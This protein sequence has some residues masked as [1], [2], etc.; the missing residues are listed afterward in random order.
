MSSLFPRPREPDARQ[1]EVARAAALP[2]GGGDDQYDELIRRIG[3]ARF[4]LLGEA[5][6]GTHE[7]YE[8]RARI[9][10]RLIAERGFGAVAIEGDW[11]DAYRVNRFVRGTME[12][13]DATQALQGFQRFPSWMWRNQAVVD[14][15]ERLRQ[16]NQGRPTAARTGFY[17]LDLYSLGASMSA[18]L[19]FL[20]QEDPVVAA[21][22]RQRYACFEPFGGDS[23]V[24]GLM[25]GL[26]STPSCEEGAVRTLLDLQQRRTRAPAGTAADPEAQFDA[27]QNALLVRDAE[28]YYRSMYLDDVSSWN[29]RDAHMAQ[30]L[31]AID[32]H[33][34][35]PGK[36]ARIVVWAH[37]SH[38]GDAY[39]TEM[40]QARG[41]LNLGQLVRER[42]PEDCYLVGF[43]THDGAVTAASEWD[44]A[45][46]HKR[47]NPSR[48][49]S[50]EGVLHA[51]GLARFLLPLRDEPRLAREFR[52][53]LLQRAIGVIYRTETERQR[54]YFHAQLARQFD[55][56]VH[57]DRTSAVVPLEVDAPW[58]LGR[59]A[60]AGEASETCPQGV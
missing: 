9:T 20:D 26:G 23:Q 46:E 17:G 34:S 18:V 32:R 60:H 38:L 30:T 22:A 59:A 10:L 57:I 43:T 37:N 25:T 48:G 7:F 55:A 28:R 29:E 24:Y 16:W 33:L 36:P 44:G 53:G 11:P 5:S 39:F 8:A 35:R 4:V 47:V 51:T 3:N 2:L 42:V 50:I 52:H 40:G 45:A 12:D 15:V 19:A 56:L 21:R 54:H 49:D 41:E 31:W 6:H 13:R 27:E 1:V 58:T 14:F